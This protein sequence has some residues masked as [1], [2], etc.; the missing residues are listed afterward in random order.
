MSTIRPKEGQIPHL[1]PVGPQGNWARGRIQGQRGGQTREFLPGDTWRGQ[2]GCSQNT[3]RTAAGRWLCAMARLRGAPLRHVLNGSLYYRHPVPAP[4]RCNAGRWLDSL[5]FG[6][7]VA[8]PQRAPAGPVCRALHCPEF[9]HGELDGTQ[10][11][12]PWGQVHL[13]SM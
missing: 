5:P 12:V 9:L 8:G 10:P 3:Q 13:F 11:C 4:P 6:R 1:P 2:V 7:G